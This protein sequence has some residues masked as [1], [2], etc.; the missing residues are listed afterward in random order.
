[1]LKRVGAVILAAGLSQ[2]MGQQKLLLPLNGKVLLAHV[3]TTA[4]QLVWADCIAVIGEPQQRL[5]QV[6]SQHHIRWIFNPARAEG[7]TSSIRLALQQLDPQLD[8]IL[9]LLG[10][11]PFISVKL[12]QTMLDQFFLHDSANTII[13][14]QYLGKNCSPVLFGAGW[15]KDLGALDGDEGGRRIIRANPDSVI[16]LEWSEP[17]DFYDSDTWE[18]YQWLL[19]VSAGQ[20][21]E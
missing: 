10:D 20:D 21:D 3:L 19:R 1:M 5:A 2:R 4:K 6:C 13:V 7:Q 8:G 15:R 17:Q 9:F 11:Q 18:Q 16:P 14:P 12:V